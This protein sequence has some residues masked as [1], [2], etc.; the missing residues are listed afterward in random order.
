MAATAGH[1]ADHR[2]YIRTAFLFKPSVVVIA[3]PL[4][5]GHAARLRDLVYHDEQ[6]DS[7]TAEMAGMAPERE[8]VLRVVRADGE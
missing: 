6:L 4:L 8:V 7:H 1:L 3:V 2:L 5:L